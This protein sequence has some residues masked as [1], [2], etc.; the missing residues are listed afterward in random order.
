MMIKKYFTTFA[1]VLGILLFI[2]CEKVEEMPTV[3][4]RG[5]NKGYRMPDPTPL[6]NEDRQVIA[7]QESEYETNVPQNN[8]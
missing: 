7:D 5:Y 3:N 2:S 4:Q 6:T 1:T 8:Q